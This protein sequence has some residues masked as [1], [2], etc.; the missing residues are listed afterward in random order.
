MRHA[1][2]YKFMKDV[3]FCYVQFWK[4]QTIDCASFGVGLNAIY[5]ILVVMLGQKQTEKVMLFDCISAKLPFR[6]I[7]AQTY[8]QP[9]YDNVVFGNAYL[10]A[11]QH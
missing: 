5:V 9:H 8:L 6:S 11:E 10:S 7:I 3:L 2:V 4:F 1:P